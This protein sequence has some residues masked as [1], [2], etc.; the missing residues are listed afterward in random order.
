MSDES[1]QFPATNWRRVC[2]NMRKRYEEKLAVQRKEYDS[3]VNIIQYRNRWLKD[4]LIEAQSKSRAKDI[5]IMIL[6]GKI[7][8]LQSKLR[9][10]E[11]LGGSNA[12][13]SPQQGDD[14]EAVVGKDGH[15]DS[16]NR[17]S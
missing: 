6:E 17:I 8:A 14:A 12:S 10:V 3:L 2:Y 15:P 5:E 9:D 4:R 11:K 1:K 13:A 7:D 16:D